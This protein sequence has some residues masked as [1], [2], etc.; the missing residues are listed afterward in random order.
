M[1]E[2]V[3]MQVYSFQNALKIIEKT[4]I[5]EHIKCNKGICDLNHAPYGFPNNFKV[6]YTLTH[7]NNFKASMYIKVNSTTQGLSFD[8]IEIVSIDA[9]PTKS[10]MGTELFEQVKIV[11]KALQVRLIW[12][13]ILDDDAAKFYQAMGCHITE[14][15][16]KYYM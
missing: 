1:D 7:N 5:S 3:I 11:A 8:N 16:F 4:T 6:E 10:G 2:L 15:K 12:G 14:R 13:I 9:E